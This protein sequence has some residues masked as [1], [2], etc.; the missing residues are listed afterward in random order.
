MH[1]R[2]ALPEPNL[3]FIDDAARHPFTFIDPPFQFNAPEVARY[4][5]GGHGPS[6]IAKHG[7]A[8]RLGLSFREA[9]S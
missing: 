3:E 9:H 1:D 5:A 2:V 8:P 6:P 4:F 7:E